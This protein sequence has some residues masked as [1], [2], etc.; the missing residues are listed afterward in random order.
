MPSKSRLPSQ[1]NAPS[2]APVVAAPEPEADAGNAF[3]QD[4][5]RQRGG[6]GPPGDA[7]GGGGGGGGAAGG[8]GGAAGGGAGAGS[9]G[10]RGAP[11]P[12][13][14]LSEMETAFQQ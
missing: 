4:Q 13:P 9:P 14:Y 5:L 8:G 10:G 6:D 3:A 2:A 7:A 1:A 11:G 12:I